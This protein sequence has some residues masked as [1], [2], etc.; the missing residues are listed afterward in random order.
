MRRSP[1]AAATLALIILFAGIGW[2][3]YAAELIGNDE[4]LPQGTSDAPI[5]RGEIWRDELIVGSTTKLS[6]NFFTNMWGNNASD[7]DIRA[8][9]HGYETVYWSTQTIFEI[10]PTVIRQSA[11]ETLPNGNRLYT[12]TLW[13]DLTYN[14][15]TPIDARDYAFSFLLSAAPQIGQIGGMTTTNEHVKGWREYS[16]G[17]L[18]YFSGIRLLDHHTFSVEIEAEYLPFFYEPFGIF[19]VNIRF[20]TYTNN[21]VDT[22]KSIRH[23]FFD[24][25]YF[26]S[27]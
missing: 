5:S 12:L 11:G 3:G 14:D 22:N 6:G 17:S 4:V 21:Y 25:M 13:D 20:A 10:N 27:K 8:M 9:L 1:L 15:G 18:P 26:R 16:S 19:K 2:P 24:F 23:Q 7:V